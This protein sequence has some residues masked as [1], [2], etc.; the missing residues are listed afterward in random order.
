MLDRDQHWLDQLPTFREL[1]ILSLRILA[2]KT[3]SIYQNVENIRRCQD[4]RVINCDFGELDNIEM[5]IDIARGCLLLQMFRV[6][7][8]GCRVEP[9]VANSLLSDLFH[10]PPRLEYLALCLEFQMDGAIFEDLARHCPQLTVLELPQT[11]LCLSLALMAKMRSFRYLESMQLATIY[12]K[13]PRR[14]MQRDSIRSLATKW[15]RAFPKLR[16]MPCTAD[17]YS[18]Y[19]LDGYLSKE[20]ADDGEVSSDE[21]TPGLRFDD[22][23]SDWFVLRTKLWRALDYPKDQIIHDKV[24]N[25][26]KTNME[27]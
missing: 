14:M 21:G 11:Q 9:R 12:F 26:W 10:A 8:G 5:L 1:L 23:D 18:R 13:N 20:S 16:G 2:S 24:Q 7:P 27:I 19:M 25:M 4:L 3:A 22:Y 15:R 6:W 17:M